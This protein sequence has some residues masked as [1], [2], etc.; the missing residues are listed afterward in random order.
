MNRFHLVVF[1]TIS[2]VIVTVASELLLV[3]RAQSKLH[4]CDKFISFYNEAQ[5]NMQLLTGERK[6]EAKCMFGLW[7]CF[8]KSRIISPIV[9]ATNSSF[10]FQLYMTIDFGW[11]WSFL[12]CYKTNQ[13]LSTSISKDCTANNPIHKVQEMAQKY[14]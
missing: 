1:T 4:N 13:Y 8:C 12:T 2:C 14:P 9:E 11:V 10:A 3:V 5:S 6:R 7:I